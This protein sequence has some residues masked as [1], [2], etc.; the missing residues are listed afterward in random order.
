MN[1]TP[2]VLVV[3]SERVAPSA[4]AGRVLGERG[5]DQQVV[6]AWDGEP[7]PTTVEACGP[8]QGVVVLGGAM[9]SMD[10]HLAP[11]LPDVRQLLRDCVET[12]FP[13]LGLCL[14]AQLLTS[15]CGGEV[16]L[17]DT[18]EFGLGWISLTPEGQDDP[19]VGHLPNPVR[20]PQFHRDGVRVL[21]PGAVV[22]ASSALY[23]VQVFRMG[24]RV[25]AIQGHPEIDADVFEDW[26]G[27]GQTD[28]LDG[29]G[30]TAAEAVSEMRAAEGELDL[31]WG[32]VVGAWADLVRA[33][34]GR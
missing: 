2:R 16:A 4:R 18:P 21:P 29:S 10:D 33:D 8:V 26:Q 27:L 20:V 6:H 23:P 9:G 14:G 13:V 30:L 11:W 24:T 28:L 19:V 31:N 34:A 22:L 25:Y 15:A 5:F 17:G 1:S 12:D 32:G 7:V 3:Q